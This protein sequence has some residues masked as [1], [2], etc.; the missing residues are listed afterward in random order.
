VRVAI[1]A[2]VST[3][4][5]ELDLQIQ[6]LTAYISAR[7]WALAFPAFQEK[8]SSAAEH[9]QKFEEM[10]KAAR[11]RQFDTL[12][13]WRYDR[14]ARSVLELHS[15]LEEFRTLGIEFV[16]LKDGV[17]TST[18]TGKLLFTLLAGIAEFNRNLTR[19]NVSAGL[20][21]A[22]EKLKT[23]PY[24]RLRD[25]KVITVTAIGRP[26]VPVDAAKVAEL[27]AQGHS[28]RQISQELGIGTGTARRAVV[29]PAKK[30]PD[31]ALVTV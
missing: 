2:R 20:A 26:R 7:G 12:L 4:P 1:Y 13:V 5:Q 9:R 16:S 30:L 17:D 21:A 28:W 15:A 10:M 18:L 29:E 3:K 25:G 31:S 8:I 6:E 22:K 19:E 11:Q 27:R 24:T 14:F 23:G